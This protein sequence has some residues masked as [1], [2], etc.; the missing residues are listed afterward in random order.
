M[1]TPIKTIYANHGK[2]LLKI[3]YS[4]H[5]MDIYDFLADN[6]ADPWMPTALTHDYLIDCLVMFCAEN[7]ENSYLL[8]EWFENCNNAILEN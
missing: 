1:K 3:I 5:P 4:M 2:T 7:V 8:M 6:D